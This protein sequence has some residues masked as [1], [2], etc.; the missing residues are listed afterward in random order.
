MMKINFKKLTLE[1][2]SGI[3]FRLWTVR[4][5]GE[6]FG[7]YTDWKQAEA[8]VS[9]LNEL[10]KAVIEPVVIEPVIIIPEETEEKVV[11]EPV[12]IIPEETEEKVE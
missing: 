5:D 10:N 11:I 6:V 9:E 7:H 12:I 8:I 2:E 3:H 1:L 4:L